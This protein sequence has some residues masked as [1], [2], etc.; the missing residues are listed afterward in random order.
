MANSAQVEKKKGVKAG[1]QKLG[2]Y[3]SSMVM[4]N[5]GAFIAWGVMT[6]L[7][8]GDG[9]LPNERLATMV[10]PTLTYLLP[11]LIAY[12]G[13]QMVYGQRGAVVGAISAMGVI[14]G[15]DIPMFIGA[16]I[17]G[18]LGG[19]CIKKFDDV[20][21]E[22]VRAGFEMLVNNFSAGLIGFGLAILAFYGI[23]PVVE[24]ISHLLSKG[25]EV[26][27]GANLLPLANVFIEPGK[28]LFL[29]N[30]I[31]HGILTPL[32]TEQAAT[33]GKSILFLLEAN[34]G[35]GLGILLAFTFFGKGSAKSSAPGA[36]I[37]QFLGGIHEIYFPYIMMKPALFLAAICGG[38]SGT[39]MFQ[40]LGAGL[41][42]ASS[43]GS[44]FAI[45]L[46]TPKG[47][48][49][50]VAILSGV[51]VGAVVSFIVASII[52]R[53]DKSQDDTFDQSKEMV[54]QQKAESKG[55]VTTTPTTSF[56]DIDKIIFACDAGMG[57]SAMGASILRDK[58]KKAGIDLPVSNSAINNLQNDPKALVVTQEELQE[59]AK[60][61]SPSSEFVAVENFMNSPRYDEIVQ[62]LLAEDVEPAPVAI[63]ATSV[64]PQATVTDDYSKVTHIIFA[65]DAGMG[66]SAMGAS[67]LR[68]LVKNNGL[69]IP[70]TNSAIGNLQDEA[71]ALIVSQ[72]ELTTR[73]T[74]KTP[75]AIHVSVDN[76]L[77]APEYDKVVATLKEAKKV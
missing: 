76:F 47:L 38:V 15:T 55:Q 9:W 44:I 64:T 73:A 71:D 16:M 17:M 69:T 46:M 72:K 29:N 18:P 35:P 70:V 77:T 54:Q 67:I 8:I 42:A 26:I 31:N 11:L 59:R 50:Y 68:K 20:F 41:K 5:I 37:I 28:V 7:F 12:T 36:I 19:W 24:M 62:R 66:S 32:G 56:N 14:M 3:L 53:M 51:I 52:L 63:P 1:A 65:C 27:V 61:K 10:T 45:L 25:V 58:V 6:A 48:S 49:N 30:A 60:R 13:G 57:S 33:S 75:S 39:F 74:Q 34:P 43:P 21:K 4:P 2:S 40:L 22:K 23:G